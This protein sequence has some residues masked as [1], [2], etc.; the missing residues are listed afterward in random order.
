[1]RETAVH[2]RA[3]RESGD[4]DDAAH[5]LADPPEAGH[6]PLGGRDAVTSDLKHHDLVSRRH[7]PPKVDAV[8]C[9]T[10]VPLGVAVLRVFHMHD[11][12]PKV[13]QQGSGERTRD[14]VGEFDDFQPAE[15]PGIN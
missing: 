11:I 6:V 13:G 15:G 7:L 4:V 14:H 9:R 10:G 5:C 2:R 3:V 12:G 8:F 1:V